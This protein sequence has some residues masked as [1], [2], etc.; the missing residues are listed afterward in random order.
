MKASTNLNPVAPPKRDASMSP[1][2]AQSQN[3]SSFGGSVFG[4]QS[5][6]G[7]SVLSHGIPTDSESSRFSTI[8]SYKYNASPTP[9]QFKN[10][11]IMKVSPNA[12][13]S[14]GNGIPRPNIHRNDPNSSPQPLEQTM[15]SIIKRAD[16]Y[17]SQ[18]QPLQN[19]VRKASPEAMSIM[20]QNLRAN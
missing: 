10:V 3:G 11:N 2:D 20:I 9:H 5:H 16:D 6:G 14:R 17:S 7:G 12:P 8:N 13:L 4:A 19:Q 1:D 18:K 15:P